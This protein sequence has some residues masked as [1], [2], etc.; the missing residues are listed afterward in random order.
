VPPENTLSRT[1]RL[2]HSTEVIPISMK[3]YAPAAAV[4]KAGKPLS[5]LRVADVCRVGDA[6]SYTGVSSHCARA[7][8]AKPA[9]FIFVETTHLVTTK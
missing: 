9:T 7:L 3:A 5:A 8:L 4:V 6:S 2:I 1:T